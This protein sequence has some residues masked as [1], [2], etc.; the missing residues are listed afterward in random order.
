MLLC[1][2]FT[3]FWLENLCSAQGRYPDQRVRRTSRLVGSLGRSL[4]KVYLTGVAGRPGQ[5][6]T[7]KKRAHT[8]RNV[9]PNYIDEFLDDHLFQHQHGRHYTCDEDIRAPADLKA[10]NKK[11]L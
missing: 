5:A 4:Q 10:I 9:I 1:V 6:K 8:Y 3:Y 7:T 2:S 11:N